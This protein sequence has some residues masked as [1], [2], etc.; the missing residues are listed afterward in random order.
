MMRTLICMVILLF[1]AGP[2]WAETSVP[3]FVIER[4]VN[5][6][7]VHYDA[8]LAPDGKLDPKEPVIAY[9]IMLAEDGHREDLN[10]LERTK[11]YGFSI[12]PDSR[13]GAY[14]MLLVAYPERPITVYQD[15]GSPKAA[16]EIAGRRAI[17]QKVY[18]DAVERLGVPKVQYIELLGRDLRTQELLSERIMAR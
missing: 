4:S 17:L 7:V 11:A 12:Q 15:A 5:K 8:R 10:W 14:R 3:L 16:V 2:A 6:N 18:I 1:T 13:P 9:W